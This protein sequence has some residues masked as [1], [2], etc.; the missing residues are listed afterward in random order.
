MY[1]IYYCYYYLFVLLKKLILTP[2]IR[3]INV[4]KTV[5]NLWKCS[6]WEVNTGWRYS[7]SSMLWDESK[8]TAPYNTILYSYIFATI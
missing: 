6:S 7:S 4:I 1:N 2:N 5:S 8:Y 3:G